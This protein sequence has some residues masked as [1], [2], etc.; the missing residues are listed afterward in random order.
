V[1]E[2]KGLAQ[3]LKYIRSCGIIGNFKA[4]DYGWFWKIDLQM[5]NFIIN[6]HRIK[7]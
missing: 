6:A 7:T 4:M 1:L 3:F 5:K 2:R